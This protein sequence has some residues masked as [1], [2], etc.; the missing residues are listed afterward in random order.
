MTQLKTFS[1]QE[2]TYMEPDFVCDYKVN[3]PLLEW[4]IG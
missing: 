2:S 4:W 1:F 3:L